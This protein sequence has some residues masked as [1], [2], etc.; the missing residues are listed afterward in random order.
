MARHNRT[1]LGTLSFLAF[2]G[3]GVLTWYALNMP[4]D[5]TPVANTDAPRPVAGE[6]A[7]KAA[8]SVPIEALPNFAETLA[9]PLFAPQRRPDPPVADK[10][11]EKVP[12][13]VAEAQPAEVAPSVAGLRLVGMMQTG[14]SAHRAMIRAGEKG[15]G[16]WMAVGDEIEGWRLSSI[17]KDRVR[18]E[19]DGQSA[20]LRLYP[21]KTSVEKQD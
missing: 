5:I 13:Q 6:I 10:P 12:E 3:A 1:G 11:P 16:S 20:E 2:A 4:I 21:D 17:E 7:A 14:P 19:H 18:L 9:R 15:A 8:P